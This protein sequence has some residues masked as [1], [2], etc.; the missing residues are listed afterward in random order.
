MPNNLKYLC[1]ADDGLIVAIF[2]HS[3]DAGI[4]CT[5]KDL[6]LMPFNV[7]NRFKEP[8]PEVGTIYKA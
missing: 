6:C 4:F 8:C 2:L 7:A 3:K 1:L 5:E